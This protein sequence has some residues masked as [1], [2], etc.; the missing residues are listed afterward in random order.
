MLPGADT[1]TTSVAE[2]MLGATALAVIVVEPPATG[3]TGTFTELELAG[4]TTDAGTVA[5]PGLLDT[6]LTVKALGAA[7]ESV[8]VTDAGI[9]WGIVIGPGGN[10]SEAPT[11]TD[12]VVDP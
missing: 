1:F 2:G 9:P 7:V 5:A 11:A 3:V 10:V 4:M 12:C 8:N 6:R